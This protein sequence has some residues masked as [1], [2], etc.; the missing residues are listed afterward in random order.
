MF[1]LFNVIYRTLTRSSHTN[2]KPIRCHEK[3]LAVV[4]SRIVYAWR[5]VY[6]EKENV[7]DALK[8]KWYV[9]WWALCRDPRHQR[10]SVSTR[11]SELLCFLERDNLIRGSV[12]NAAVCRRPSSSHATDCLRAIIM[13]RHQAGW[14]A[15][16]IN[17]LMRAE[18]M[19]SMDLQPQP[20][21]HCHA[22]C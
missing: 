11:S 20:C 19:C 8:N 1:S 18:W 12:L 22:K 3:P 5:A 7:S 21:D 2:L 10:Q 15:M 13:Y 14:L 6:G 9:C 17:K 4:K 16:Q